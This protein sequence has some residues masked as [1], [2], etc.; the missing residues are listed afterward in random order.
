MDE[1]AR[2]E[3]THYCKITG[4]ANYKYLDNASFALKSPVSFVIPADS[5]ELIRFSGTD[6]LCWC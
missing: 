5:D 2:V 6:C 3:Q 1:E 4:A